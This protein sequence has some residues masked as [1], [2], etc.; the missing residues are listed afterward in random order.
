MDDNIP[1]TLEVAKS[2]GCGCEV[3]GEELN[4]SFWTVL[5]RQLSAIILLFC[6]V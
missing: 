6:K 5:L 1:A 4:K 2:Y 3:N